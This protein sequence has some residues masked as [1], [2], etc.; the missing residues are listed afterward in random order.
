LTTLAGDRLI[1]FGL[2]RHPAAEAPRL[3]APLVMHL[4]GS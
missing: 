1:D 2:G 3:T 4:A